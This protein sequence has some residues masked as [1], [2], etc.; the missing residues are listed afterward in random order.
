MTYGE[1]I[2]ALADPRRRAIFETLRHRPRTVGEIA[3]G[4]PVSRPAVSQHLKV[5]EGAGLVQ[6]RPEGT[7]RY[8][9]LRPEG[10]AELRAWVDGFWTDVLAGFAAEVDKQQGERH[11]R[12]DQENH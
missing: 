7:R 3:A 1:A 9:G 12:A 6:V 10:L 8:Y 4:Q 11:D 5:L 2:A